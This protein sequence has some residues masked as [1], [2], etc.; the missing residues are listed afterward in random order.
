MTVADPTPRVGPGKSTIRQPQAR[1]RSLPSD[2]LGWSW[3][4]LGLAG[5]ILITVTA[6][7]LTGGGWWFNVDLPPGG[8]ANNVVFYLGIAALTCAWLGTGARLARSPEMR[9]SELWTAG[10]IWC[11]PLLLA[12][13]L[14]SRD[15]YSYLAQGA[16]FHLGRNPY[17]DAPVILGHLGR[18]HVLNAVSPF[19][20]TTTAPYGPAFIAIMSAIVGLTGSH[21]IAAA[22][23]ARLLELAGI[24]LL[25]AFIPR[26]ARRLGADPL[27]ATWIAVISPLVL[28]ELI[29]AGHNDALMAGLMVAGVTVGLERRPAVGIAICAAAATIKLPAA[30]AAVFIAVAWARS[31]PDTATG[32]RVL[33]Q[34]TLVAVAVIAA[35]SLLT[36]LGLGWIST[37]LFST[38]AKVHLAITPA[39]AVG[40]TIGPVLGVGSKA[41]AHG[42]GVVAAAA[43]VLLGVAMIWR[44]RFENLVR[45]LAVLL[46]VAALAG[47]AAWPWY[48]VWGLV[49]LA[50]CPGIQRSRAIPLA[51]VLSV[52]LVKP[53]GILVLPVTAA[54]YVL[55]VYVV[56]ASLAWQGV[57]RQAAVGRA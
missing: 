40:W 3:L 48:F 54:P 49:L 42:V 19:W 39:T 6:P 41:L 13:P 10:A 7:R 33:A 32:A 51:V 29:G 2:R 1:R 8:G 12:P 31:A 50:A 11:A 20:R 46:L 45:Y 34:A 28:L 23:L 15:I 47:P 9:L 21:L 55:V 24:V 17:H 26:L 14:F 35:I 43:T 22:I 5:S 38:P 57:R 27:W 4:S 18:Q 16:I 37:S 36:G 44:V 53:N 52:F 56:L 30:A 25:A